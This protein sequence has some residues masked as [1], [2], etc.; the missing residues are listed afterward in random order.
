MKFIE[1]YLST[2]RTERTQ[3]CKTLYINIFEQENYLKLV[4]IVYAEIP[5]H[6]VK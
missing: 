6:I 3:D 4:I 5:D 2:P 1:A